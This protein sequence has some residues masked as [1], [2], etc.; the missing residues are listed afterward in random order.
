MN[1]NALMGLIALIVVV[2]GGV[3]FF[4]SQGNTGADVQ[5]TQNEETGEQMTEGAGTFAELMTRSGSWKCTVQVDIAEAPSEGIVL[6]SDG[7]IRSDFTSRPTSMGGKEISAHMIHADGYVYTWS[8]L[9]P[10]GMKMK[11]TADAT[12]SGNNPGAIAPDQRVNYSCLPWVVDA[13][14]F[15]VPSTITFMELSAQGQMVPAY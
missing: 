11:V 4:S 5:G 6:V 9:I 1:T 8:D 2:G 7:K 14:Q 13:S 3:W 10:Q 12:T 15:T